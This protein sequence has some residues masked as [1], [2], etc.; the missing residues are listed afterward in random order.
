[1]LVKVLLNYLVSHPLHIEK[2]SRVIM[3]QEETRYRDMKIRPIYTWYVGMCIHIYT[4]IL[5]NIYIYIY[6]YIYMCIYYID[7]CA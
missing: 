5:A 2:G 4:H 1:M 3:V 7:I 6:I